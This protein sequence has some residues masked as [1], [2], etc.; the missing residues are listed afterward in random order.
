[1][2]ETNAVFDPEAP[3]NGLP[4]LPPARDVETRRVLKAVIAAREQLGMLNTACR[5]IPNPGII[6]STIPLREAQASSEIENIVTT[7]DELFRAAWK[8]DVAPSPETKEALRYNK[9][10]HTAVASLNDRPVSEQTAIQVCSILQD[11][12]AQIRSTPGTFIGNP[13]TGKRIYTPPEGREI[14]LGHL[15]AWERFIYS[16]HGLDPLV[17]LA[18]THYQFEAIHPFY[19][20]NG[21][22]GRILNI[23]MLIQDD[24]LKLPVLYLSGYIMSTKSQYYRLLREVT[25]DGNWEEWIL[26][27][28]NGVEQ[29]AREAIQLI[30]DL[31]E[32]Q[33]VLEAEIRAVGGIAPVRELAELLLVNPYIRISNLVDSGLVKRQTAA[34]WL[35]KLA[36]AGILAEVRTGREKIFI[37]TKALEVLSRK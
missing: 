24:M 9:A 25:S 14:I 27:M 17:L 31:R 2:T 7:N 11:A 28:I 30:D 10:L 22:T 36:A 8:V 19:D 18:V 23:L 33:D 21:R 3:F 20:G 1:M 32:L 6:T 12:P 13:A 35:A 26:Y 15:S 29:A 34:T 37:N 16:D 5:L 4:P